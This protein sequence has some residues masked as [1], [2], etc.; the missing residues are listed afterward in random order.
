MSMRIPVQC[1]SIVFGIRKDFYQAGVSCTLID[2]DEQIHSLVFLD[3]LA[4][5]DIFKAFDCTKLHNARGK[6]VN[7]ELDDKGK[8]LGLSGYERETIIAYCEPELS[9]SK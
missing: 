6:W 8:P 1:I 4:V 3:S 5:R 7:L 9:Y 2:A